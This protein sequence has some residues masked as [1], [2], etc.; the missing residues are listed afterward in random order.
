MASDNATVVSYLNKQGGDP[1]FGN[2]SKGTAPDGILK[3][4]GSAH[5]GLSECDSRQPFMQEQDHTNRMVSSSQDFS[6]DLPNLAQTNGR[7][8]C[9]QTNQVLFED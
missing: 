8:V 9:N 3:P 1:F 2:V 4:Q 6:E 7:Y 5:P